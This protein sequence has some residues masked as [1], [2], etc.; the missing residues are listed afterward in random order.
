MDEVTCTCQPPAQV[1]QCP[2]LV[3]EVET[4]DTGAATWLGKFL[5]NIIGVVF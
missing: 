2:V 1:D 4:Q 5:G 3:M